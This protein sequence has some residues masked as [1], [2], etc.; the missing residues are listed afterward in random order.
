MYIVHWMHKG[1]EQMLLC[2]NTEAL[3]KTV[4]L[5]MREDIKYDIEVL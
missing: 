1:M 2:V 3:R 4:S 5:F